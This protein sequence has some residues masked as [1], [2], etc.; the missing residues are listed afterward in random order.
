MM[1]GSDDIRTI[2]LMFAGPIYAKRSYFYRAHKTCGE[3]KPSD[4]FIL[5]MIK[6]NGD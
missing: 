1:I 3:T 2:S 6:R 5:D 4:G